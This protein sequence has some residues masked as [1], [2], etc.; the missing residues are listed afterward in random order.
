[1]LVLAGGALLPA[2]AADT[3]D[4]ITPMALTAIMRD[5]AQDMQAIAA[6]IAHEDWPKA[7]IVA[8]RIADHPQPPF[9]EKLRILAFVGN[10][11]PRFRSYD[12]QVHQAA[13]QLAQ[14][15]QRADG[16]ATISAFATLQTA[17]LGC[18]QQFR[19]PF[20][21]HFHDRH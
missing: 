21:K 7:A 5:L 3:P 11:T 19:Q 12:Q 10:D 1:M 16:T 8:A 17:C 15:A 6:A 14:A 13:Q 9:S 18:H 4:R 20:R 2:S